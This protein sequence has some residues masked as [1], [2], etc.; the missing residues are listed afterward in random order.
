MRR[1]PRPVRGRGTCCEELERRALRPG[2]RGP[3]GAVRGDGVAG[4]R[5]AGRGRRARRRGRPQPGRDRRRRASRAPCP[6][7]TR[8]GWWPCAARPSCEL[9]GTRRHGVG[10]LPE[11]EGGTLLA[12]WGDDAVGRRRQRARARSWSPATPARWR[13]WSP[14]ARPA[15][16]G[17]APC[18][19]TTPRTPPTS[20]RSRTDLA[21]VLAPVAPRTA[22]R[23]AVL[24]RS[25]ATGWPR[26]PSWTRTTGTATCARPSCSNRPPAACSPRDTACSWR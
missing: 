22:R 23:T 25:P 7:R 12:A 9:S 13:S 21:R 26:T 2:G 20:R 8:P 11:E 3:A 10:P 14:R 4:R 6:W 15:A 1:R 17:P 5:V 18:P 24:H 16:S 19:S